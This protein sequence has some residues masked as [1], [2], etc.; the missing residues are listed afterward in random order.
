MTH[1]ELRLWFLETLNKHYLSLF[2]HYVINT[3]NKHPKLYITIDNLIAYLLGEDPNTDRQDLLESYLIWVLN[4]AKRNLSFNPNLKFICSKSKATE[5]IEKHNKSELKVTPCEK[6][7]ATNAL[8]LKPLRK[9]IVG[10]F[11]GYPWDHIHKY[12]KENLR[13]KL[14]LKLLKLYEMQDL[15]IN[16]PVVTMIDELLFCTLGSNFWEE[17]KLQGGGNIDDFK[18][19][20]YSEIEYFMLIHAKMLKTFDMPVINM[21]GYSQSKITVGSTEATYGDLLLWNNI[22]TNNSMEATR[23]ILDKTKVQDIFELKSLITNGVNL[24]ERQG[25]TMKLGVWE[26]IKEGLIDRELKLAQKR[27][28]RGLYEKSKE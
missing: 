1:D 2:G 26:I 7:I 24:F 10:Y 14:A 6:F 23:W 9:N 20:T 19:H 21:L 22:I 4:F 5:F 3:E 12:N 8:M 28:E 25:S 27:L 13:Y 15:V 18:M 11:F 17:R 16:R